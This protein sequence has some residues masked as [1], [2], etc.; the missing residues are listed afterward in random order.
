MEQGFPGTNEQQFGRTSSVIMF[1]IYI[2]YILFPE[3]HFLV[4]KE[5]SQ[6]V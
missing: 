5:M 3:C 4:R 2:L 6:L 1:G